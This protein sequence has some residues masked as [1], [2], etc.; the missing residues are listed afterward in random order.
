MVIW[1]P[2]GRLD[3]MRSTEPSEIG[4]ARASHALILAA[5]P[6]ALTFARAAETADM[7]LSPPQT[8]APNFPASAK[9]V[10]APQQGSSSDCPGAIP[11]SLSIAAA[12]GGL[13]EPALWAFLYSRSWSGP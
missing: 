10:P 13:S 6:A 9:I 12:T 2:Q 5:T 11:T 1:R 3:T 7:S 4:K 8:A